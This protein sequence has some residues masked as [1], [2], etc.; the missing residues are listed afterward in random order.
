MPVGLYQVRV[1]VRLGEHFSCREEIHS[2]ARAWD[3]RDGQELCIFC[4]PY[5]GPSFI[6]CIKAILLMVAEAGDISMGKW[7]RNA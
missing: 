7:I 1:R 6:R 5:S 4:L 3:Y 2:H